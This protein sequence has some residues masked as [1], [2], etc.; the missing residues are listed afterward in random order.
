MSCSAAASLPGM[1]RVSRGSRLS[2]PAAEPGLTTSAASTSPDY[3]SQGE[4]ADPCETDGFAFGRPV[5]TLHVEPF[6]ASLPPDLARLRGL[7]H[8]LGAWLA[9]V[10]VSD[11]KR[12]A[13]VLAI[14]EAAANAIEHAS[15]NVT[16]RGARGSDRLLLVVS[17][18]GRWRDPKPS[19]FER[20]RGLTLVRALMS[21]VEIHVE[22]ERT[23]VRMRLDVSDDAEATLEVRRGVAQLAEQRSPKP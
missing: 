13:V 10:G 19:D 17:N 9:D 16:V 14:H 18:A 3:F 2:S 5:K 23:T 1:S 11:A 12:D 21:N 7:R 20:G 15:G 4:R 8:E 22:H 6:E